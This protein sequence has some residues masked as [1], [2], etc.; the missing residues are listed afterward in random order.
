MPRRGV[1]QRRSDTR[2]APS[3]RGECDQLAPGRVEL[4]L[5]TVAAADDARHEAGCVAGPPTTPAGSVRR[6]HARPRHS[7]RSTSARRASSA[8]Q[9]TAPVVVVARLSAGRVGGADQQPAGVVAELGALPA[10][11]VTASG[12]PAPSRSKAADRAV[13]YPATR[14]ELVPGD[15]DATGRSRRRRGRRRPAGHA[16]RGRS[17]GACPGG[18]DD[19]HAPPGGVVLDVSTRP[20]GLRAHR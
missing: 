18:I 9:A 10:V 3:R 19:R 17:C 4:D 15:V 16:C 20:A 13:R 14:P 12:R 1:R 7:S 8:D 5:P 2:R 11:S 6:R